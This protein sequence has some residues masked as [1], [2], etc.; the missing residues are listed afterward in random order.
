MMFTAARTAG[1]PKRVG[2]MGEFP[3]P[4]PDPAFV[5]HEEVIRN[6][7][8]W[9]WTTS[10]SDP[11]VVTNLGI[12]TRGMGMHYKMVN[13]VCD[14]VVFEHVKVTLRPGSA[15]IDLPIAPKFVIDKFFIPDGHI[16]GADRG[17]WQLEAQVDAS[18]LIVLGYEIAGGDVGPARIASEDTELRFH[19][20]T[21]LTK[22]LRN[23]NSH[24]Q[25]PLRCIVCLSV[26]C[27]KENNDWE[28][29]RVLGAARF[30]PHVM[31]YCTSSLHEVEASVLIDRPRNAMNHGDPEMEET[32]EIRPMF[33]TDTNRNTD[34]YIH[35]PETLGLGE[36][37]LGFPP[38]PLWSNF[39]DYYK[40]DPFPIN[41]DRFPQTDRFPGHQVSLA[42]PKNLLPGELCFVDARRTRDRTVSGAINLLKND[43]KVQH[44]FRAY[45]E[46]V[47]FT[48]LERQGE[49][50]N[51][52]LAPRMR[53]AFEYRLAG[54]RQKTDVAM[55]PFCVHDCL[56]MHVR[57][58]TL[59]KVFPKHVKG[60]AG[61]KP[62]REAGRPMV[63]AN[64]SVFISLPSAH[65]FRYRAVASGPTEPNE[66][67]VFF[68]HGAAQSVDIWPTS[69]VRRDLDLARM[70]VQSMAE[71]AQE[72]FTRPIPATPS[73]SDSWGAFYWRLR[74]GGTS[75]FAF[76]SYDL[77]PPERERVDI[78]DLVK[79]RLG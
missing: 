44:R 32:A 24:R 56:H 34:N 23:N 21:K 20:R 17:W 50:D 55:A 13:R 67:T 52:H 4:S 49:F 2:R 3:S 53:F 57:W 48:K 51:V 62:Y 43:P 68:H 22:T 33:F 58:G 63:P 74:F 9:S 16:A 26:T 12:R 73:A 79:C 30:Y 25:T 11:R 72:P 27:C 39:F 47:D 31:V 69:E 1:G 29:G 15:A 45:Y 14:R 70:A 38:L 42:G 76:T 61:S 77:D 18:L 10:A 37:R 60:F 66:W 19:R 41:D 46:P 59:T 8:I 5:D 65:S 7:P 35:G 64:Q 28:A 71:S 40:L 36:A 78:V 6:T 75:D 54:K